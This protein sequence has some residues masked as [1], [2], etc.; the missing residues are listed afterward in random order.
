MLRD[1]WEGSSVLEAPTLLY[2]DTV[3]DKQ[4]GAEVPGLGHKAPHVVPRVLGHN[5]DQ[6]PQG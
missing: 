5:F 2:L 6:L 1:A 3:E 4:V